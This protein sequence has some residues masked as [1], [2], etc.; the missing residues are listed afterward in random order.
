MQGAFS[1]RMCLKG[2]LY[3]LKIAHN[4]PILGLPHE[5]LREN[6]HFNANAAKS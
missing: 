3:F 1:K 5:S 4:V 2:I 6:D